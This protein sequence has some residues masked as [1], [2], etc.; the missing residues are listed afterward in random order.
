MKRIQEI[1]KG[2]SRLQQYIFC[3][4]AQQHTIT[5][6]ATFT[7]SDFPGGPVIKMSS[8]NAGDEDLISAQGIEI[9][10]AL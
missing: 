9:P 2:E 6:Y 4:F 8:S 10:H 1:P 7:L 5:A 3:L